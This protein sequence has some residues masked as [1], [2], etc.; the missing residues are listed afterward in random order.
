MT[1][2]KDEERGVDHRRDGMISQSNPENRIY[3]K[4]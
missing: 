2:L 1:T 4:A 3:Q